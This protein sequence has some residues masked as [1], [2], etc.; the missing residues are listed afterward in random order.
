[1]DA[2][3]LAEL[4]NRELACKCCVA[5][6]GVTGRRF[7]TKS[8]CLYEGTIKLHFLRVSRIQEQDSHEPNQDLYNTIH[9]LKHF[10]LLSQ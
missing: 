8:I 5:E 2:M 4:E 6:S 9:V 3:P 7:R 1:M 10:M